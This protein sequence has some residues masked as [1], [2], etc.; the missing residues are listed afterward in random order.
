L[1]KLGCVPKK[2]LILTFPTEEQ[3]P[4]E[5]IYDFIRGYIDGD[6]YIQ[7]DYI[8]HRYRIIIAGTKAFL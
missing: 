7:Y 1:I 8:K 6:G 4:Q 5:F 3:V 2:S